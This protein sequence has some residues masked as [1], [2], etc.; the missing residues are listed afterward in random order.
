MQLR[1][2]L[3]I[4][5]F[6]ALTG[7]EWH[8]KHW[9]RLTKDFDFHSNCS[10]HWTSRP[11]RVRSWRWWRDDDLERCYKSNEPAL[12]HKNQIWPAKISSFD[13]LRKLESE[14]FDRIFIS[15]NLPWSIPIA[16][17]RRQKARIKNYQLLRTFYNYVTHTSIVERQEYYQLCPMQLR[18][19]FVIQEPPC[20]SSH[21][22]QTYICWNRQ[23]KIVISDTISSIN[24]HIMSRY[25]SYLE[26]E[27]ISKLTYL[28][29]LH[30][31][32]I[33]THLQ[34]IH[35]SV[36]KYQHQLAT[37][38]SLHITQIH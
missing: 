7:S 30:T 3:K 9:S 37:S 25:A 8:T 34:W 11:L 38:W 2:H 20:K 18:T 6:S 36:S 32:K 26:K 35:P 12:Q 23:Q 15:Y 16:T 33:A 10:V 21:R 24:Y 17:F 4:M 5:N 14:S 28:Q 13:Q 1:H 22:C 31:E 29:S 27:D 19:I